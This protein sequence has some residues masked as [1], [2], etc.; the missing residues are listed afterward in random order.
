MFDSFTAFHF[1]CFEK[2]KFVFICCLFQ[3][4]QMTLLFD[5]AKT[6]SWLRLDHHHREQR[7]K[8]FLREQPL[9]LART[10]SMFPVEG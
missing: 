10:S 9:K 8:N 1:R 3:P 6:E 5:R 4:L 7:T 2:S